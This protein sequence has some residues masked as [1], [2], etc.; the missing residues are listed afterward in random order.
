MN[1]LE[2]LFPMGIDV[3]VGK[4][5]INVQPITFGMLPT[6][7]KY[8]APVVGTLTE[9]GIV[10]VVEIQVENAAPERKLVFAKDLLSRLSNV[11]EIGGEPLVCLVAAAIK[12]PRSFMDDVA[13]DEGIALAKA[14][15]E[16]NSELLLKKVLP[17]LGMNMTP[18][19]APDGG[20]SSENSSQEGTV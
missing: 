3:T 4:A 16:V 8:L 7:T 10:Q 6:V 13:L 9:S 20:S 12:K 15:I 14:I 5:V 1:D 18:T 11:L 2:V 17:M 19:P